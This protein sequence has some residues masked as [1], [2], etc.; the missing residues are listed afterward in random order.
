MTFLFVD[1]NVLLHYRRLEEIDWLGLSRAREV[2]I[3]L[4]PVV[5][6]ELEQKKVFHPQKKIRQRAQEIIASLHSELSGAGSDIVKKGV[7]LEF[8]AEDPGI[9]FAAHRLRQELSD[10]WLIASALDWKQKHSG[11]ET[12]IVSGDLGISIKAKAYKIPVV[13]PLETDKLAD[14]LDADEKRIRDLTRELAELKNALRCLRLFFWEQPEDKNFLRFEIPPASAFD[15]VEAESTINQLRSQYPQIPLPNEAHNRAAEKEQ[16]KQ[17]RKAL[18]NLSADLRVPQNA[19]HAPIPILRTDAERYNSE[20]AAFYQSYETYL[21]R[22]HEYQ[23]ARRL[24]ISFGIGLRNTGSAPGEDIDVYLHFPD[25]FQ[26]FS[27][28]E[29]LPSAP[30]PPDPPRRPGSFGIDRSTAEAFMR[31]ST[32]GGLAMRG[33]VGPPPNVSSPSIRRTN[34]YESRSHIIKAKHGYTLRLANFV[35][36]FGSDESLSSFKIDYSI[37][38]A[39][40]PKAVKDH[41]SIIVEKQG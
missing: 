3:V 24:L 10:D 15:K 28:E 2:V 14:E 25:G 38:A 22:L 4:C 17:W 5:I 9:D 35:A 18:S 19:V 12:R 27:R 30:Q 8:V 20:L 32:I 34:S 41:L 36:A 7:R 6:R 33:P 16:R 13:R 37:S 21:R 39:N 29:D 26:L 1:T 40:L 11:D 23:N 31:M